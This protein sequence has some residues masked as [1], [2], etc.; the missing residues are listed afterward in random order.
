M[1]ETNL[2]VPLLITRKFLYL[3]TKYPCIQVVNVAGLIA[4]VLS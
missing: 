3:L 2:I 4:C 1:T